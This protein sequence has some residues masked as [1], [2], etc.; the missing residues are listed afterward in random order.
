[1]MVGLTLLPRHLCANFQTD[2]ETEGVIETEEEIAI[3]VID[4]MVEEEMS[5]IG[6]RGIIET[7]GNEVDMNIETGIDTTKVEVEEGHMTMMTEEII[8]VVVEEKMRVSQSQ[9][10]GIGTEDHVGR[11]MLMLL[12]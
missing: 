11:K 6:A 7:E 12:L 10:V 2:E 4:V 9:W 5:G 1:M 3:E 8:H